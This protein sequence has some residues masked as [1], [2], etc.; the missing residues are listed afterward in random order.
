MNGMIKKMSVSLFAAR[1]PG[2]LVWLLITVP[3]IPNAQ[4]GAPGGSKAKMKADRSM[5][6]IGEP[7]RIALEADI[8]E[9]E[10]IGFF[11]M[12]SIPHFEVLRKEKMDTANTS[13]GTV[14]SQVIWIT[15]FD[16]GHWVIPGFLLRD[17][18]FTDSLPVDVG[19]TPYDATKPYHD[20]KEIIDV[21]EEKKEDNKLWWVISGA[22][23][24][25]GIGLFFYLRKRKKVP[26]VI[27]VK[28]VDPY[29]EAV[30]GLRN[31]QGQTH[32]SRVYYSRL[33]EIFRVYVFK[34]KGIESLQQTSDEL[35]RKLRQAGLEK[36]VADGLPDSLR[37]GDMVKFARFEPTNEDDDTAFRII[38]ESIVAIEEEENKTKP[39][40]NTK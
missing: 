2:I 8:P 22:I 15:S 31:L 3:F 34:R 28:P 10:A 17:S 16:S 7:I 33:I 37:M 1:V 4:T 26:E 9:N 24:L 25:V 40:T 36:L 29:E 13:K 18:I 23:L 19:Y 6:L 5:I 12:D 14:L 35:I 27:A 38:G 20:V 32:D 39:G 30:S 11:R 21:E